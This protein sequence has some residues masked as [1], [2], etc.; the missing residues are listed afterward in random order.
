MATEEEV[1]DQGGYW[2]GT[3]SQ[4]QNE[5]VLRCS[6]RRKSVVEIQSQH[7]EALESMQKR[8]PNTPVHTLIR[9]LKARSFDVNKASAMYES[10]EQWRKQTFPLPKSECQK[11]LATRKFYMLEHL[12]DEGRPVI[13]YCLHRFMEMPYKVEDEIKALIFLL[14]DQVLPRFGPSMET[15]QFTV[16]IDVSGIRSPPISFLQNVNVVM[17]ANYPET[18][19]RSIM[20]PVP[21]WLQ[22]MIQGL[23]TF[24]AEDTRNKMAYVND[25]KSLEEFAGMSVEKMGPDISEL[26]L[27][28]QLKR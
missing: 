2:L 3:D 8:F 24:V 23:T 4:G 6:A 11:T 13:V 9:F 10:H 17:E 22:K 5:Q 28:K 1:K 12:D 21:Y 18:L 26:V 20:F 7:G 19:H 27:K 14:E 16:L 25:V 15:Q